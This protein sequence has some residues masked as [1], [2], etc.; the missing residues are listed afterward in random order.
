MKKKTPQHQGK[1]QTYPSPTEYAKKKKEIRLVMKKNPTPKE[2]QKNKTYQ[3]SAL[4]Q[5]GP[6]SQQVEI[7][8]KKGEKSVNN[9]KETPQHQKK[10]KRTK[11]TNCPRYSNTYK[12]VQ[13]SIS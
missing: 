1:N 11:F 10:S 13:T 12:L 8:R 4:F 5:A 7:Y 6:Y 9:K 2:K 3:L